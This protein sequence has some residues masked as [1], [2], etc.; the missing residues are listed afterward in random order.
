M[1][2]FGLLHHMNGSEV[3]RRMVFRP[4]CWRIHFSLSLR[5]IVFSSNYEPRLFGNVFLASLLHA[6]YK[7][8]RL[9][10]NIKCARQS[11]NF[12]RKVDFTRRFPVLI[13]ACP[14][15]DSTTSCGMSSAK[16][17]RRKTW[18]KTWHKSK[19]MEFRKRN[20]EGFQNAVALARGEK[21]Q[22]TPP[23]ISKDGYPN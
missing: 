22:V 13:S 5:T 3:K 9:Q 20:L 19:V 11:S 23:R 12:S 18:R 8:T 17:Y 16:R 14:G 21:G 2:S 15:M 4:P 7:I 1:E 6:N 10:L